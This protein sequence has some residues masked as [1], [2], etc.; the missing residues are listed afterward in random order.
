MSASLNTK[1]LKRLCLVILSPDLLQHKGD[2]LG[3][4]WFARKEGT[5]QEKGHGLAEETG[6][7]SAVDSGG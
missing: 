2:P 6:N 4:P 5:G 7:G 3:G 1:F